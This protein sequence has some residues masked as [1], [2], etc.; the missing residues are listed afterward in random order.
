MFLVLYGLMGYRKT[1]VRDNLQRSFPEKTTAELR[2]IEVAYYRH[3]CDVVLESFKLL[4]MSR[5]DLIKRCHV[6]NSEVYY[7]LLRERRSI[8]VALGHQGNWEWAG[9]VTAA[10]GNVPLNVIYRPLSNKHFDRLMLRIRSRFGADPVAANDILRKLY[11]EQHVPSTTAFL[12]DQ[13]PAPEHAYWVDFLHQTTPVFAGTEKIAR[14]FNYP[15]LFAEMKKIKR[16]HYEVEIRMVA[17][18][19]MQLRVGEITRLHTKALETCIVAQ[20]HTWLWSHRRWKHK[21]PATLRQ[22][23][24]GAA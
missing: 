9:A 22:N 5:D 13:T 10:R 14:K 24:T 11:A 18:E 1:V 23:V 7:A 21:P 4:G 12:A 6:K 17:D 2:R 8:I 3:L 19:P 16:G 20:P 15:V